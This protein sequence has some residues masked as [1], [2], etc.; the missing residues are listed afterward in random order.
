MERGR[1]SLVGNSIRNILRR[2]APVR[3]PFIG[4]LLGGD[5][6]VDDDCYVRMLMIMIVVPLQ[7]LVRRRFIGILLGENVM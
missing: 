2:P 6:D 7:A 4:T 3:R 1:A 5:V